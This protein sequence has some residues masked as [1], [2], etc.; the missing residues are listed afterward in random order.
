MD[1]SRPQKGKY[2]DS[3]YWHY[4]NNKSERPSIKADLLNHYKKTKDHEVL[5][6]V[7]ALNLHSSS[8]SLE[9][10]TEI[11]DKND[12]YPNLQARYLQIIGYH[13]FIGTLNYEKA[14]NAYI[15]LEKL[16]DT[17][18]NQTITDYANY[19]G[20]LASAYYKFKNYKKAIELG[21]KGLP[22][23]NNKWDFYNTI[24][25]CYLELNQTDSSIYYFKNAVY[26]A[27]AKKMP[28]VYR[29]IAMGNLGYNY[30][31]LKQ[32]NKAKPLIKIDLTEASRINDY[33]LA[34]GAAI[35]LADIYLKEKNW[36]V[37]DT[38]LAKA[39]NYIAQSKQ[40]ERLEKFFPVRSRYYQLTGNPAAAL[41][42][43]DSAI[44]AIKRNDSVYNGLLVMRVQQRSDLEKITEEKSKLASYKKLSQTR[45]VA[46]IA[47]FILS[48]IIF[49]L[50]RYYHNRI[51]KDKKR[52]KELN[53]IME[54]R[55][56]LS[57]DMH[58]DIGSTLSSI[59]LYT[60]SLLLQPQAESYKN[61]LEK[62][63]QNAQ[64]VQE[65]ISDIIW[66]VNPNMDS[67]EQLIVRMRTFGSDVCENMHINFTFETDEGIKSQV[68]NMTVRKNL[69]LL[70]KETVNNAVKYSRCKNLNVGLNINA[71]HITMYIDDDGQGFD[72]SQKY[73]GNG[74]ENMKRRAKEIKA[75]L[76]ISSKPKQGTCVQLIVPLT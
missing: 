61:T 31:I 7:E 69:Y 29:T 58:D 76:T 30:Y 59:S 65:S 13:N 68:T 15:Q 71:E 50:M 47:V 14:F 39:R 53:R 24:G 8:A 33:G 48:V 41:A 36:R 45:L 27:K 12:S 21:K 22:Y 55:Q 2:L 5:A 38:L 67:M 18:S 1:Q 20:E 46:I 62:I 49:I 32:F 72:T 10:L 54:L 25:L 70:Y 52:I 42:Y 75:L 51:N 16:L 64:N 74:I 19:C 40:L 66:S 56:R 73:P 60:H 26:E 63:K 44:Q 35:P 34:A 57:A 23:T 3:I 9:K 43:R 37:A 11:I 28:N 6:F 17:Y 4:R